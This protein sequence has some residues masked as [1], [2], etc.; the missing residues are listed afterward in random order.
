MARRKGGSGRPRKGSAKAQEAVEKPSE[1]RKGVRKKKPPP[2]NVPDTL[3]LAGRYADCKGN[4]KV[5]EA[6]VKAL[7]EELNSLGDKLLLAFGRHGV[8]SMRVAGV[9]IFVFQD[10]FVNVLA[11]DREEACKLLKDAGLEFLVEESPK[12]GD[13]K[14]W[15]KEQPTD[16]QTGLP[17]LPPELAKVISISDKIEVRSRSAK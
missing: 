8:E 11:A 5:A 2:E 12:K 6:T 7:K 4:L 9:S 15:A 1:K 3:A 17:V 16:K 14:A 10:I 13:L